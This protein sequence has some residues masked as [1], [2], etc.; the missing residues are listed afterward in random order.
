[1]N[2]QPPKKR[3]HSTLQ[4]PSH[5]QL[6]DSGEPNYFERQFN[7]KNSLIITMKL[8]DKFR[9]IFNFKMVFFK[10]IKIKHNNKNR[11]LPWIFMWFASLA[12]HKS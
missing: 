8:S 9:L 11:I 5:T 10:I 7:K 4:N 12:F 6:I 2:G 3:S 1:M